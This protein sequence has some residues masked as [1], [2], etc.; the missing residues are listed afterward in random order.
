M[1]ETPCQRALASL[2]RHFAPALQGMA[3]SGSVGATARLKLDTEEIEAGEVELSFDPLACRVTADPPTAD[4]NRLKSGPVTIQVSTA[5]GAPMDW[6]L[7]AANPHYT[8]LPRISATLRS[9][10]VAAE[11]SRFFQHQGFDPQ[12]LR[13]AF[14]AN[15]KEGRMLR[16]ASTI[17][18]QLI[19]NVFLDQRRN[20]ARKVQEAVLTWRLEQ[21][22]PK[23]RILEL[24]LNLVEMGPGIYGVGQASRAYF[25]RP[26]S[27]LSRLQAAQ[28]AALT[29]SPRH[30]APRLR[31]GTLGQA[32]TDKIQTLLRIMRR[33]S[34]Q[35]PKPPQV[36]LVSEM[37]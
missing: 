20:L 17:S 10:F 15:L 3:L 18:Q 37:R 29:P 34:A 6:E 16:G 8:P 32:W 13:R 12:Q 36:S 25:K 23:Q 9:A 30:L 31:E 14:F 35:A 22:V 26:P 5:R 4:V 27:E 1:P 21:V 28:L 11:D 33:S 2:P 7:G 19:K 24:Y